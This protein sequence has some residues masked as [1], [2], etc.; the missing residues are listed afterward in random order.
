MFE[1]LGKLFRLSCLRCVENSS[2]DSLGKSFAK[3]IGGKL[4]S[5]GNLLESNLTNWECIVF[6]RSRRLL[7]YVASQGRLLSQRDIL[8]YL[9]RLIPYNSSILFNIT[10]AR[11]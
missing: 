9:R 8:S 6:F 7:P 2:F 10:Y 4:D 11:N 1:S 5:S 3:E